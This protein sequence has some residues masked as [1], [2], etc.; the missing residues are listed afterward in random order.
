MQEIEVG[1]L[2][3]A[4]YNPRTISE[5]D[6]LHLIESL[7]KFGLVE[8]IV[9]NKD[10]TVIGGHQRLEASKRMGKEKVACIIVDLDKR[11]EKILNIALNKISGSWDEEKL[12]D[13]IADLKGEIIGFNDEEIDQYAMRSEMMLDLKGEYKPEDDE[14]LKMLFERN[15]R[16]GIKVEEPDAFFKKNQLAF[17]ADNF[18]NYIKI[19]KV[20]STGRQGELDINKL[21][22]LIK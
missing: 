20:F 15:E 21:L 10:M 12:A 2:K 11:E 6:M 8:P 19:K 4:E 3:P 1:K 13:I 17:Y 7:E 14:D 5:D 18:D 16:V 9:V 22:E